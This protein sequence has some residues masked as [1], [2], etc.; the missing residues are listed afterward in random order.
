MRK[1]RWLEFLAAYDFGIEYTLGKGNKVA[2]AFSRK[3]QNAV[4][5]MIAEWKDLEALT[6]CRIQWKLLCCHVQKFDQ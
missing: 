4:L 2:D 1:Q 3:H 6:T 5:A